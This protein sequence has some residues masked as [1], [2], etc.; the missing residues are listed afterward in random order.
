[1]QSVLGEITKLRN[2]APM[3]ID[4]QNSNRYRLVVKE[5]DGT[6]TAYYFSVPIYNSKNR[7]LIDMRFSKNENAIYAVGSNATTTIMKDIRM[8]NADGLCRIQLQQTPTLVSDKE[9]SCGN[10]RFELTSNGMAVKCPVT[11]VGKFNFTIEVGEPFLNVRANNRCFALMKERFRPLVVFSCIGSMDDS[12]SVIAPAKMEYQKITDRKYHL[13]VTSTS[14]LARYILFEGNLYENKI[15]QDT[16]VESKNPTINNAFGSVGFIGDT[17]IY[18]EQWL[19]SRPNFSLMP[20]IREKR[21]E[22]AI[23]HLPKLNKG[24]VKIRAFNVKSRFCSFGSN[25]DN[26]IQEGISIS[27]SSV[28]GRYQSIELTPLLIDPRTKRITQTEGFILKPE[29]K[30]NGFSVIGTG[31]SY[32]APQILQI[33]YR[34]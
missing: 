23:L 34:P 13:T 12:G 1:M 9:L 2:G 11:G 30:G 33:N 14:P 7:K 10:I 19:Y 15:F 5:D 27:D 24:S 16:T 3:I 4:Y 25:W 32:L 31:D 6:K 22:K 17:V 20:E 21:I 29:M 28:N 8:E 26:K 18:G